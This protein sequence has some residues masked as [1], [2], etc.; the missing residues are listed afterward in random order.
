MR[1]LRLLWVTP[2][3]PRRGVSAA[4]ERWWQLLAR[5]ASRHAVTLLAFVD[6][7]DEAAASLLPPGLTATHLVPRRPHRPEDPLALLPQAVA[8]GLACPDFRAAVAARLA[9]DA[10]DVVQYEFTEAAY[11]IPAETDVRSILTVHQ[12]GFAQERPAWRAA[13]GGPRMAAVRF[14]R[15]LRELDFGLG[16]VGCVDRVVTMS[17]EDAA[18]LRR[19]HADLPLSVSPCG[20]DCDELRP[21][22]A[23]EPP[24]VDLVFLGHFGHPPNVDAVQFLVRDVMPRLGR[25]V[26]LRIVGRGVVPAVAALARPGSVE[27]AGAVDDVR[28]HLLDGAAFVAPVRFGTG[29]RGKVLEALALGRPVVTTTV[30]AEGLGARPGHH[31]LVADGAADFAAAVARVLGDPAFAS[32]LGAR[33]RSLV[34]ARFDWGAIAAAHDAIY[35]AVLRDPPRAAPRP[36][37]SGGRLAPLAARLGYLPGVALG[38]GLLGARALRWHARRPSTSAARRVLDRPVH[39]RGGNPA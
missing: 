31:L 4:R 3:L 7:E 27:I 33:G 1:R 14:H 29:M 20:V 25:P 36:L 34:E 10:Y 8:G 23:P 21:P 26:R 11:C 2:Q 24:A 15:W 39:A 9:A 19:F 38:V 22:P 30:G 16:A 12:V 35:D 5:L 37:A 18:R 6:P 13:G 17:S 32:E 28:P